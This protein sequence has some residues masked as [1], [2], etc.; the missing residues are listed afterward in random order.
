MLFSKENEAG[1]MQ[2]APVNALDLLKNDHRKV[3]ALFEQFED[4]EGDLKVALAQQICTEL[5]VHAM[6][7]E[8][9][10][11]PAAR[12]ALDDDSEDL[13][14][15]AAVEHRSL[16]MLIAEIDGQ[17]ADDKLFEAN[18]TVLKEYVEH[19]V[20]EEENE[21]FPKLES[22]ELDLEALGQRLMQMK[23]EL[24]EQIGEPRAPRAGTRAH[25]HVPMM[26]RKEKS[27]SKS[28]G[29]SHRSTS[30]SAHH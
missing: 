15:E 3:S 18:V 5:T 1:D 17:A 10:F 23:T 16:K 9:L 29:N 6:C 28:S 22:S 20:K 8:K 27:S 2:A 30:R 12:K 21:M 19:H 25:V 24:M 11:Y 4:A 7:E 26:E 13:V 14:D